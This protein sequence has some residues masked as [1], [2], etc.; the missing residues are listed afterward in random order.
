MKF[1]VLF[2]SH[3]KFYQTKITKSYQFR[4]ERLRKL[5]TT[6]KKY[7]PKILEALALDL[8]KS[9]EESILTEVSVVL[10]D[11]NHTIKNLRRWMKSKK[12]KTPLVLFPGKSKI[13]KEP[14]GT[15]LILS[16]WNYPFQLAM[17]PLIGAI[18]GGN[19]VVLKPSPL[20]EHTSLVI[21]EIIDEIFSSDFVSCVLGGIEEANQLLDL[22]FD[23]I[24]FTG[25]T[26]VGKHV[27]EKASKNLTP[28]TLELGGKS[29]VYIDETFDLDLAAK[30]IV[31]GK[32]INAGQTCIAPDYLFIKEGLEETFIKHAM[33][34]VE[35]FYTA[36][37]IEANNYPK[38]ITE[39]HLKRQL[40][41]I[42]P[43]HVVYGG[44][45][46]K[47]KLEPTFLL[48]VKKEDQVMQEEI[49]GPILPIMIYQELD[50]VIS[51]IL[52][53]DKPL[54]FYVFSNN[55][56]AVKKLMH[57]ISFGGATV[58]DTLMH[59]VNQNLPFGGVGGS[60]MGAYHGKYSFDTFTHQKPILTRGKLDL[61][62]RYQ[63]V[64]KRTLK[65]LRKF[66]K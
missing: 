46:N 50:E 56:N 36:N 45:S 61:P 20:S 8:G 66:T 58:N 30:R 62:F 44:K 10:S 27:M 12:V 21:K 31:F 5:Q 3:K 18:A 55:K 54:A 17:N 38:L 29:P 37:P 48:N 23:Y 26:N 6:I 35:A 28:V 16:P 59:F 41:L 11:L 9:H 53:H 2:T 57:T 60:G 4:I 25:S 1:D 43:H 47:E 32:L 34:H 49:F 39:R 22:K 42:E 40:A 52:E 7:E 19:T 65:I 14:Y 63:P 13:V 15:V 64:N 33:K 51:Y 24:F